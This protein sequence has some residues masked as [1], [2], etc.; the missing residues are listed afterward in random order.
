MWDLEL[1]L[2]LLLFYKEIIM[3]L[4]KFLFSIYLSIR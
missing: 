3:E 2:S 1:L 4:P